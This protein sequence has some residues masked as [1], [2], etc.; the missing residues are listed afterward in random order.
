MRL[1]VVFLLDYLVYLLPLVLEGVQVYLIIHSGYLTFLL[2]AG[3]SPMLDG[4]GD[5]VAN[6]PVSISMMV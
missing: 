6:T 4:R 5:H 3:Y 2:V 1:P